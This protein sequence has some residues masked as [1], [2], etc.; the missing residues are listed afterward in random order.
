MKSEVYA[1]ENGFKAHKEQVIYQQDGEKLIDG[2][3]VWSE[4]Y[5]S[6]KSLPDFYKSQYSRY[7]YKADEDK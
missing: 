5:E 2:Y 3:E 1:K 7:C 4:L 6:D